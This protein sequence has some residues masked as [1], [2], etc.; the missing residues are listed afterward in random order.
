LAKDTPSVE[1]DLVEYDHLIK[2]K[3]IE[4]DHKFEDYYNPNS[5]FVT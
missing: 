5:K 1:V 3:T 2:V 4:E